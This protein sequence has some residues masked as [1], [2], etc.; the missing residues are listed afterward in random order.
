VEFRANFLDALNMTNFFLANAP[1]STS[2]GQTTSAFRD[3][4]GSNDPG[5]RIVEFMLRVNF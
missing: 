2:F 5:A 3:F 1:S 4:S